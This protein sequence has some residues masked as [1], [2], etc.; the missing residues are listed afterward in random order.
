MIRTEVDVCPITNEVWWNRNVTYSKF[1]RQGIEIICASFL[2]P[3]PKANI[4]FICGLCESFIKYSETF[5]FLFECGFNVHTYD[6][7]SQ[8][9]S[10]RC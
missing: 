7:Q 10:G 6:H 4:L 8:G 2:Q 9:L 5:Q 1:R 3:K